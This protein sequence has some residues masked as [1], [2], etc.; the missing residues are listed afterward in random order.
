MGEDRFL[1]DILPE[2]ITAL[3][4]ARSKCVRVR[5]G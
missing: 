1:K 5:Q 4:I 2:D 3:R